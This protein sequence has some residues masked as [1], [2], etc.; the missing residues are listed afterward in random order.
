MIRKAVLGISLACMTL[1]V[2]P[3]RAQTGQ[4][5]SG[6]QSQQATKSVSGKVLSIGTS[7]T[8]FTLGVDGDNKQTMEFVV[9]KDTQLRGPVKAGTLVAV[10]Y[11]PNQ[12]G[13]NVA[14]TIT[15]RA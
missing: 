9:N 14:V 1:L 2:L 12:S 3:V 13:P 6:K 8:S 4:A 5:D 10:E 7:G 15:P 11:Q